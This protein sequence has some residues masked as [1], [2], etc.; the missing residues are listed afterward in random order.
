[1]NTLYLRFNWKWN[2]WISK[3]WGQVGWP[4]V[5]FLLAPFIFMS[6][7]FNLHRIKYLCQS[8]S[9]NK[10]LRI[11]YKWNKTLNILNVFL[12]CY[13]HLHTF[14]YFYLSFTHCITNITLH[15]NAVYTRFVEIV[16]KFSPIFIIL[17]ILLFC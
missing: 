13:K 9:Q 15:Y 2:A 16:N 11:F 14:F 12:Y 8:P 10:S 5:R 3:W 6:R 4:S 7:K 1:M 17:A